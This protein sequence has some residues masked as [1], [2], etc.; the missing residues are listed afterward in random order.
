MEQKLILVVCGAGINTSTMAGEF[1]SEEIAKRKI[2]NV[3]VKTVL[4]NDLP[5]YEGQKNMAI[6]FM[7]KADTDMDVPSFQG[8]NFLIGTRDSK[9]ELFDK[10]IDS[11]GIEQQE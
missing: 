5:R 6:V 11:L 3:K 4:V 10:I 2:P 9:L 7:T 8:M 1:I